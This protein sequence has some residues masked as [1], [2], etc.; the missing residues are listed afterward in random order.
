MNRH[1]WHVTQR[2]QRAIDVADGFDTIYREGFSW[3]DAPA[4]AG[5]TEAQ[6]KHAIAA[7]ERAGFADYSWRN[8]AAPRFMAYVEPRGPT[9]RGE[10]LI[11]TSVS[12]WFPSPDLG[13]RFMI[14]VDNADDVD[15]N[16]LDSFLPKPSFAVTLVDAVAI[17]NRLS[18]MLAE[19]AYSE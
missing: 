7:C 8:D 18:A 11:D 3:L 9:G 2:A 17:L 16:E 5:M 10:R 15:V 12:I 4:E 14:S 6:W 13:P 19:N 1:Q